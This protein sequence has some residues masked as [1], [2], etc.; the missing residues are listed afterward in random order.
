MGTESRERKRR[1]ERSQRKR[2]GRLHTQFKE[3]GGKG[4]L[5]GQVREPLPPGGVL[6]ALPMLTWH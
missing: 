4:R 5:E 1:M 3:K 2:R 6:E